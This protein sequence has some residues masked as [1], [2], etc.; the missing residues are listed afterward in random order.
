MNAEISQLYAPLQ[1]YIKKRI[2]NVED[3]EDI[4]QDVFLKL[5]ISSYENV[6]NVKSQVYAIAKNTITDFYRKKKIE[7]NEIQEEQVGE[8]E[9]EGNEALELST[10]V[11]FYINQLP[12]EYREIMLLSEIKEVPQKELAEQLGMNYTTLR[13]KVQRG[14]KKLK[15]L[16]TACCNIKQ[17]GK[18]SIIGVEKRNDCSSSC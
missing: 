15:E 14:R 5:S 2:N 9:V 4:T 12:E 8:D 17:G 16:F 11:E 13:S 10:C 6:K 18:G 3:A 1:G 7:F